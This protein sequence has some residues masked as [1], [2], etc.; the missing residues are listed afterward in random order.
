M[1]NL[2]AVATY[3]ELLLEVLLGSIR[4]G[5]NRGAS[6]L[7]VGW[8]HLAIVGSCV[9]EGLHKAQ[10]FIHTA[11]HLVVIDMSM[12]HHALGVNDEQTPGC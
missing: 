4:V 7:P 2:L 5:H 6:R 3:L 9:L 12:L 10:R 11:A 1:E 8:A